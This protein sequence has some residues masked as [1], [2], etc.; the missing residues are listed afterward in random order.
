MFTAPKDSIL[1]GI[2]RDTI[3]T[4]SQTL[5]IDTICEKF[6]ESRLKNADEVILCSSGKELTP[7]VRIDDTDIGDGTPGNI[8]RR[9]GAFYREI[10]EGRIQEFEKWLTYV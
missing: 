6:D 3:L 5:G 8:A 9:L 4:I 2:T 10:I 1:L 7:I